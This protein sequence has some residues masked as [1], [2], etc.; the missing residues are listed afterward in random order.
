MDGGDL[1]LNVAVGYLDAKFKRYIDS[2]GIDVSS[3]RH[4]QNTPKW[5]VSETLTYSLPVGDGDLTASGTASYR[6]ASQQFE[7]RTPFLDQRGYTLFDANL[8][9]AFGKNGRFSVG[10]HG[11]NLANK[12]YIVSGYNFLR[13]NPD[14]GN[15][16][17]ANGQPGFN[18][19]LGNTGVLTAYYGNPRQVFGTVGLKF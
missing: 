17:L 4:I 19:T 13:Q 15:F 3:R 10:V 8:V 7:I 12:R 5:T 14:T 16:I 9:Y 1:S 18:S 11:R 6:S 2:R